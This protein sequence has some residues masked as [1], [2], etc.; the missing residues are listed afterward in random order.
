MKECIKTD[1]TLVTIVMALY[2]PNIKWLVE[3]LTSLN[4]QDYPNL[5]LIAID[6]CS[7]NADF[8]GISEIFAK[9]ITNFSYKLLQNKTNLG[10]T[11]TFEKLTNMV[12]FGYI[13]YCDQDDIWEKDKVSQSVKTLE[14]TGATLV[15]GDARIIDADG[16]ITAESVN[17]VFKRNV[18]LSGQ[19]LFEK[20]IFR[21]FVIGCTIL[22]PINIAKSAI[23]FISNGMV[24]DHW[25]AIFASIQGK[26]SVCDE[27]I[28]RYRIHGSN[29]TGVLAGISTKIDY[30]NKRIEPFL[31][32]INEISGRVDSFEELEKAK[33]WAEARVH[34]FKGKF[35]NIVTLWKL[36]NLDKKVTYFEILLKF[37]P[38]FIFKKVIKS[39]QTGKI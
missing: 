11:K 27:Q 12:Q 3:Q 38:N 18:F 39:L 7:P 31:C 19:H 9:N 2:N 8:M 24:H 22:M 23:P 37:M 34:Y 33:I 1:N 6:D 17:D 4:C 10:S 30:F 25:L 36:R 20:L 5:E 26:I 35:K 16:K 14:N 28:M 32:R 13:S 29:Q 21:N 15:C